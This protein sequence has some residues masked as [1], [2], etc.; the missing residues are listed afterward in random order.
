MCSG[1]AVVQDDYERLLRVIA[2]LKSKHSEVTR[3]WKE[4]TGFTVNLGK[5]YICSLDR[6]QGLYDDILGYSQLLNEIGADISLEL[7]QFSFGITSRVKTQNSIADKIENYKGE[8]HEFGK[9]PINKCLNDLFGARIV[10]Q[11]T[12]SFGD[13]HQFVSQYCPQVFRCID[14]SKNG[15]RATH[16]YFKFD[17]FSFQWELQVWNEKDRVNN[18]L[19]HKQYKQAYIKWEKE[20]EQE[21]EKG[22]IAN[23]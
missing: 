23:D 3:V 14:S 20:S 10:L 17:N 6:G 18:L 22:G 8:R 7:S 16:L 11:E 1:G 19:S 12:H 2:Y 4:H 21:N 13:I 5:T 9:I 15:Y